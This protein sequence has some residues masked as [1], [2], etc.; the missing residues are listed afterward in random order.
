MNKLILSI[1]TVAAF[2]ISASAQFISGPQTFSVTTN[3]GAILV[4]GSFTT[5]LPSA[6]KRLIPIGRNGIGVFVEV[7]ATNAA[8]TTNATLVFEQVNVDAAGNYHVSDNGTFTVSVPQ[9]GTTGYDYFTNIQATAANLGNSDYVRLYSIQ[10]TNLASLWF[11][12]IL[13]KI[14]E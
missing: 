1:L 3:T 11:T 13:V 4:T 9:S 10:N 8:S 12:N 7:G 14:R 2:A 5:N 6:A